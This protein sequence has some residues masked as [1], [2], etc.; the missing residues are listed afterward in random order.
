L[1][2][3]IGKFL[4]FKFFFK[5]FFLRFCPICR[6][7]EYQKKTCLIGYYVYLN[8]KSIYIQKIIRG[9]LERKKYFRLLLNKYPNK[10]RE[11]IL[12]KVKSLND[13]IINH[14]NKESAILDLFFQK[15]DNSIE[16]SKL[17]SLTN[18]DWEGIIK[19]ARIRN[20]IS[21]PICLQ[22]F[23]SK[24]TVVLTSCTHAFHLKVFFFF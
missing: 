11:Y 15:I 8:D 7:K 14:V 9:F 21:C 4:I 22:E 18:N 13:K 23:N 17:D 12:N 16:K 2:K 24:S 10:K 5:F 3:K 1:E 19:V 6:N 20:E